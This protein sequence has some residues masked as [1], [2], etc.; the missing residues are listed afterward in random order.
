[1]AAQPF[2]CGRV[3]RAY[4]RR[5]DASRPHEEAFD[6]ASAKAEGLAASRAAV[7]AACLAAV[8][9]LLAVLW[10]PGR[11]GRRRRNSP[12]SQFARRSRPGRTGELGECRR[13]RP[14]FRRLALMA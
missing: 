14:V 8:P 13:E 9:W 11:P 1:M 7:L 2:E 12:G 5:L 6:R 3:K 10:R 4:N